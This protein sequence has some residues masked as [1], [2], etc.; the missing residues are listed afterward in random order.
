MSFLPRSLLIFALIVPLAI[1]MGFS[2]AGP[3]GITSLIILGG[4]IMLLLTPFLLKHYHAALLASWN[5]F[6]I[7]FFLPG[8]PYLWMLLTVIGFGLMILVRALNRDTMKFHFLPSVA[9]PLLALA[10]IAYITANLTGGV[11]LF[12]MGSD[13]FGGKKYFYIWFAV[14]AFF[15][16]TS[17]PIPPERVNIL[18]GLFFLGGVTAC[19]SNLAYMLGSDFYF[20]VPA[21]SY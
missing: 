17:R 20:F 15:V 7:V 5:A 6:V 8:R 4:T 12:A 16:L 3:L 14:A 11:G 13:V 1:L 21:L 2:L 18:A 19:F 9:L 10:I